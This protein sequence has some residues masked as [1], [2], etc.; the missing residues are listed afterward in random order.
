MVVDFAGCVWS[1][2]F[3]RRVCTTFAD[4]QHHEAHHFCAAG[5]RLVYCLHSARGF[6]LSGVSLGLHYPD[7]NV[8]SVFDPLFLVPSKGTAPFRVANPMES[9]PAL[10]HIPA[11][12]VLVAG[13]VNAW[14]MALQRRLG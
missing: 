3:E 9:V 13:P 6:P 7:G 5:R 12:S 1:D 11:V 14:V 10:Y 8:D 2:H 4:G